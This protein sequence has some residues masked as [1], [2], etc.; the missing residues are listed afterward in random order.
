MWIYLTGEGFC[1]ATE[2]ELASRALEAKVEAD[3]ATR[4]AAASKARL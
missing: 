2:E 1:A 3:S 4:E